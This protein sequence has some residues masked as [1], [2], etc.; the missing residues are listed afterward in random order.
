MA[1]HPYF[2]NKK[3]II[4]IFFVSILWFL[5]GRNDR[6]TT[7]TL[8]DTYGMRT[9]ILLRKTASNQAAILTKNNQTTRAWLLFGRS[10]RIR[11]CGI[12]LPNKS[13]P[14]FSLIYKAFRG[15]L[16]QKRCFQ[17]LLQALFPRSPK[18]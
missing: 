2:S 6:V 18:L 7:L 3:A 4:P 16:V 11:T 12:V 1:K 15:F 17:V 14:I 13:A 5:Y 9:C 8:R 10:D